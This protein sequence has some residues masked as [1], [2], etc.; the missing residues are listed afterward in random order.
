MP[1]I[2]SPLANRHPGDIDFWIVQWHVVF[3][4]VDNNAENV[5]IEDYH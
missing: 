4:W 1:G 2:A 3:H 5:I